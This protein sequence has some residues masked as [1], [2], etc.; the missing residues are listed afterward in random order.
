MIRSAPA[1]LAALASR[2]DA[3]L[4]T[5]VRANAAQVQPDKATVKALQERVRQHAAAL[6]IEPEIL[7][8]RRDLVAV[9]LGNPPDHLRT[10]WR[11]K[12]LAAIL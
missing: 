4:Q 2:T 9:A 8:T 6:N 7:A 5:E 11:A 10:G 12:E 1:L 3:A